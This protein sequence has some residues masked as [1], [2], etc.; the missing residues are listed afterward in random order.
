MSPA[1][2]HPTEGFDLSDPDVDD[3]LAA[4][5]AAIQERITP[6]PSTA[7]ANEIDAAKAAARQA[8]LDRQQAVVDAVAGVGDELAKLGGSFL[9]PGLGK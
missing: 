7:E 5:Q 1:A 6:K 4:E 8:E 2:K 3:Q 9:E